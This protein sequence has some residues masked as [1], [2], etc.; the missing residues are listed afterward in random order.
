MSSV[1]MVSFSNFVRSAG[2]PN[3]SSSSSSVR[4]ARSRGLQKMLPILPGSIS[5]PVP[6]ATDA[7][8]CI[9]ASPSGSSGRSV[10]P[11]YRPFRDHSVSPE[12]NNRQYVDWPVWK[13]GGRGE[14]HRAKRRH[15]IM[16]IQICLA[17]HV[18]S[19]TLSTLL[20]LCPTY[21]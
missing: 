7:V 3:C 9:L 6:N 5:R 15:I 12:D 17:Y 4:L 18:V 19:E 14:C 1:V 21:Y 16:T 8:C 13:A 10:T 20:S 11:V 2:S